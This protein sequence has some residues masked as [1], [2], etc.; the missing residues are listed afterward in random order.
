MD[1]KDILNK[2]FFA[3][4]FSEGQPYAKTL[5]RYKEI[6]CNYSQ[7]ENAIAVLSDW[8]TN[9]S[10]IY[11]GGFLQMLGIDKNVKES[12]VASIWEEEIFR[13]IHPDD[14]AEKHLQELCFYHFVKRQPKKK[15][16]DY[17]LMSK[18]RMKSKAG[19]YISVLHRIFYV[20]MPANDTLWLALCLYSPLAFDIPAKCMIV[21]SI[22]GHATELEEH[23]NDKILSMR[24]KQV[25]KLINKGLMSKE[26]A[27]MLSI[28]I[29]TVNRH[30]QEILSKLQV[31]NSIE[32]CRIAKDLKLI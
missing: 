4:D 17:Y 16:T 2:E 23:N 24:E 22:D 26:I 5:N 12:K 8:R 20:S 7:M 10:Y 32:A 25:L 21:N 31:K 18:L 6:A 28:S 19:S 30:R 13:I 9:E 29:Y 14:L 15:R 11:Y 27:E 1:T 3:Q